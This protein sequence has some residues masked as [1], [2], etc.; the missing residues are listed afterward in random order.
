VLILG[1]LPQIYPSLSRALRHIYA[2]EGIVGL[3]HGVLQTH[4]TLQCSRGSNELTSIMC[5]SGLPAAVV[6]IVPNVALQFGIYEA[7][8]DFQRRRH[9]Q[10]VRQSLANRSN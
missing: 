1:H 10:I 8:K 9:D 2:S 7:L 5:Y 4:R 6:G 3:Y